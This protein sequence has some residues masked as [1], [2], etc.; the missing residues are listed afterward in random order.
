M[1]NKS[2]KRSIPLHT[3]KNFAAP[4]RQNF[5]AVTIENSLLSILQKIS[6]EVTIPVCLRRCGETGRIENIRRAA[7]GLEKGYQGRFF[8]DSDLYKVLEGAA[9]SLSLRRDEE[10][11]RRCDEIIE[12]IAAAQQPDGYIV[13]YFI[14]E[15]PEA[16]WTDMDNHEMYCIGHLIE[17][18]VAYHMSTGKPALLETATRAADLLYEKFGP[19]GEPWVPGHEEIELALYKLA[20]HTHNPRYSDL[21]SHLL[22]RRGKGYGR[23]RSWNTPGWGAAYS[24]DHLPVEHQQRIE[25]H[26]VRA[27]YLCTAMADSLTV[28]HRP[29]YRDALNRLWDNLIHRNYYLTGG[30]GSSGTNEGF[31]TD[32]DLPNRSAYCE[33]CASVGLFLWASRMLQLSCTGKYGDVMERVLFNAVLGA[34]SLSGDRFFYENP[35][36]SD[37][38]HHR[39]PWYTVSCCPTQLSRFIPSIG[40]SLY[41]VEPGALTVNLYTAGSARIQWEDGGVHITQKHQ[42]PWDGEL[43]FRLDNLHGHLHTLKFRIPGWCRHYTIRRISQ[44]AFHQSL[45]DGFLVLTGSFRSGDQLALTL[46]MPVQFVTADRRIPENRGK[47]ALQRGPIVYCFEEHDNHGIQDR[48]SAERFSGFTLEPLNFGPD[49]NACSIV[50]TTDEKPVTAVPYFAWDNRSEGPMLI[51]IPGS[52]ADLSRLSPNALKAESNLYTYFEADRYL[53]P[54]TSDRIS[55]PG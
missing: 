44:E 10:L 26:A 52:P 19:S 20:A 25:G 40:G 55:P 35:L 45:V 36:A 15:H 37:G 11:E 31:T 5:T 51:W 18:A 23:G 39:S 1:E 16:K 49:P 4:E 8:N 54:P 2:I 48:I 53:Q 24:Q 47:T 34:V 50:F 13:T 7:R 42:Y 30:I 3:K 22:S 9:Y 33:T 14:I 6:R 32:Y 12:S 29:D 43:N 17:A 27:M 38:T 21:A 41:L 46:E 28:A